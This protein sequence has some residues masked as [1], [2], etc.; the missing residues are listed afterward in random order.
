MFRSFLLSFALLT[1]GAVA[2]QPPNAQLFVFDIRVG[3]TIVALTNPRYLSAFNPGGYNDHPNWA[4]A[5]T[6]YASIRMPA[7]A[8]PDLYAFDLSSG[9]RSRLTDTES[10][11][12]SP[13]KTLS[14]ARFTAIR[15]EYRERDTL[16]R[17]WEFPADLSDNGRPVFTAARG[18]GYYEW[19]NNNQL[20]LFMV[21]QPN[22]LQLASIGGEPMRTLATNT[23]RTFTRLSSGNLVYVDKSQTPFQLVEKSLYRLDDAPTNIAPM[24]SGAEDFVVLADGS[25]LAGRDDK[26]YRLVPSG[27]NTWTEVVDLSAYGLNGISRLSLNNRGQLALVALTR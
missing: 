11:E 9:T 4:D 10:G 26:L 1:I 15:Q 18:M 12:Y 3:D 2:A 7:M 17:L 16:L 20:A 27:L 23:G 24:L 6:L 25:Y 5:N 21:G 13:K 22:T 14:G 19:L 8:Q